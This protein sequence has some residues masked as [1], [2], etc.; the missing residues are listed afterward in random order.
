MKSKLRQLAMAALVSAAFNLASAATRYVDVN[1]ASPTPPYTSWATAAAT[2]QDAVDVAL[3]GDQLLVTNGVYQTGSRV[4]VG[5]ETNRVVVDKALHVVSVN[6]PQFTLIDGSGLMRCVYLTNGASL[7]GFSLTNGATTGSGGGVL[8]ESVSEVI[9]NCV[10]IG[11]SAF[12]GGGAWGG[13]LDQSTLDSNSALASGG[14]A[15]GSRLSNCILTGNSAGDGG[16][17]SFATLNN[18]TLSNNS[19]AYFGGGVFVGTLTNCTLRFNGASSGGGAAATWDPGWSELVLVNCTLEY[20]G[21]SWGLFPY[22][23]TG[24]GVHAGLLIDC[25]L[26]GNTALWGGGAYGSDLS[27]CTL[28]NNRAQ[29]TGGGVREVRATNCTFTGNSAQFDGGGAYDSRLDRC[30]FTN[31][32]ASSGGGSAYGSLNNCVLTGNSASLGGGVSRGKLTNCVLSGNTASSGGGAESAR[33]YNCLL[34]G[35]SATNYGGGGSLYCDLF[36][37][38]LT[39][40]SARY[41]GGTFEGNTTNCIVYFNAAATQGANFFYDSGIARMGFCCTT[42]MPTNGTG[43]ITNAPLFVDTNGWANL[44]L[45]SNS[46]CINAADN[47]MSSGAADMDGRPRVQGGTADMGAYEFQPGV[48]GEFIGW[49]SQFGLPTDGSADHSDADT[50]LMNNWQEWIAGTIPT[51]AMSAL[52]LLTPT[53]GVSGTIVSWQSV[54]NRTY[55]LERTSELGAQPS[56]ALLT[57]NIV[58]QIGTTSFT[59]TNAT[60]PGPFFYRIGIQP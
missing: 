14:G 12:N 32:S 58:G 37:C 54:S 23:G 10:I 60:S 28:K 8:C 16:G 4:L 39:G 22:D 44:R 57:N 26:T 11:N 5:D 25:V 9:S 1:S 27:R 31:N 51:D 36:N 15:F 19:A 38:T 48:S 41:G 50:D 6:G 56:F 3:A 30:T 24:G 59:D 2:I 34:T 47:A 21:V 49:L 52:R 33:L 29:D 35:N 53:P 46:P 42:P 43:N 55:F 13:M 20:N 40:N 17:A 18:C 45:Q 7:S